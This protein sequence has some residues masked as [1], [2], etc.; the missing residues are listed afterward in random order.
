ML[1]CL[2]HAPALPLT[3][4]RCVQFGSSVTGGEADGGGGGLNL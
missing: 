1:G 3:R 2:F 4:T